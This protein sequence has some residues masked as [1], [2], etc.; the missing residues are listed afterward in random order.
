MEAGQ[1]WIKLQLSGKLVYLVIQSILLY[2]AFCEK[3]KKVCQNAHLLFLCTKPRL[4]QAGALLLPKD[5]VSLSITF[6]TMTK[7][8]FRPYNPNQTV[9]FP[10]RIDEDIAEHDPVRMVDALVESLTLESFRKLY[11]ECGRSPY[12]PRMMLKVILYAYMNNI[13]SCR[14]IEKL[15]HRDIHY[16]WLAGYEKPDFITINRFRNRVKNEI[17]EVFTQTV[18]LLS[19]KG[20]ISLN[21][22]YI[23]GTKI[24][25]KANKYTFVWRKTVERNR[26]RLMKKIHILLGQIDN[27][28]AQENSSESNEEIEFTPA[29]LTEMAGELRQALEQVPEPSTKEE[30]TALK[31]KRKQLKELEEHR[32]KLQEYDNRLDTL[33]DRNSYSKTDNDATFMRIKEDAMRNGQTKPGYNLQIGTGNQFIFQ[34]YFIAWKNANVIHTEFSADMCQNLMAIFQFN[35]EHCVWQLLYYGSFNFNYVC[36]GHILSLLMLMGCYKD[37]ISGSPSVIRMVFS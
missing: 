14:K 28:I 30:K 1:K 22:E 23:D 15:L 27:V 24:E 10:P 18:L 8:H 11:K 19:S 26:E 21:V 3:I 32:D 16:I 12:H 9:L 5:F 7:I 33:Q 20:F 25:S 29:M 34:S 17:N 36:F 13:Y 4:S 6:Y 35:L 37:K 2:F 31:K